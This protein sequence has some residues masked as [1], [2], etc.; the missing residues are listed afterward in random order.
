[1][2]VRTGL[3]FQGNEIKLATAERVGSLPTTNLFA[4]RMV[5]VIT[6]G[7][8]SNPDTGKYYYY[9]G[10]SWIPIEE[11]NIVT[12]IDKTSTNSQIPTAK[13]VQDKIQKEMTDDVDE[14]STVSGK[15]VK[16][17]VDKITDSIIANMSNDVSDGGDVPILQFN[18]ECSIY[19]SLT[20]PNIAPDTQTN[21]ETTGYQDNLP[22]GY[23]L[24]GPAI[25]YRN[26][27]FNR[28]KV[29]VMR[30]G[31]VRI[32]IIRGTGSDCKDRIA[33]G[34]FKKDTR[35]DDYDDYPLSLL[36]DDNATDS[37]CDGQS[38]TMLKKWLVTKFCAYTGVQVFDFPDEIITSPHE[39]I[40]VECRSGT[41]GYMKNNTGAAIE[42]NYGTVPNGTCHTGISMNDSYVTWSDLQSGKYFLSRDMLCDS[43]CFSHGIATTLN[44]S[45]AQGFKTVSWNMVNGTEYVDNN[46]MGAL[47]IGIYRRG[48][49]SD[50]YF[51]PLA[52]EAYRKWDFETN[53]LSTMVCRGYAPGGYEAQQKLAKAK[54]PIYAFEVILAQPGDLSMFLFSSKDPATCKVLKHWTFRLRAIGKQFVHLPEDIVLNE[55]EWIGFGGCTE[56]LTKNPPDADT[57]FETGTTTLKSG[58]FDF[59]IPVYRP[60]A[61]KTFDN[62]NC[63]GDNALTGRHQNEGDYSSAIE[64]FTSGFCYWSGVKYSPTTETE[65]GHLDFTNATFHDTTTYAEYGNTNLCICLHTRSGKISKL[66]DLWCSVTGDSITTYRNVIPHKD[67]FVSK[68]NTIGDYAICYPDAG[69]GLVNSQDN[70][71]W[72]TLIKQT[73]MRFLINEAWSGSKVSGTDSDTAS[74]ACASLIRTSKLHNTIT[75]Y[76]VNTN[77]KLGSPYAY[78]D[79][80]FCMIG[81][82]DIA[83][84]VATGA[85]SNN[86]VTSMDTILGAFETMVYRHKIN[87]PHT[88]RIYFII[89]RGTN[90]YPYQNSNAFSISQFADSAEYI[91]KAFGSYFVPLSYFG[92]L[93]SGYS[94]FSANQCIWIPNGNW[95]RCPGGFEGGIPRD[96]CDHLH[97]APVGNQIIANGLQRFCEN[98]L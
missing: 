59:A 14:I 83:G 19:Y 84:N 75:T 98:I 65:R 95:Y 86:D 60:D 15:G 4:G 73:R 92:S 9:N 70:T 53:P 96:N 30:P 76:A 69:S 36:D 10:E 62:W 21:P 90:S 87:Y 3:D 52:E 64:E 35:Y 18:N 55:G 22:G 67:D 7:E 93:D 29:F 58:Y 85:Y 33:R 78:P 94:G 20:N 97:P 38:H 11:P 24:T 40:F 37:T 68:N 89:P 66:E 13:A 47:N 16:D 8:N 45:P 56:A 12:T 23:V 34:C 2:K 28:I 41:I 61:S 32:G 74:T 1:M 46:Y 54:L 63:F 17:Y 49:T 71:W 80:I 77:N 91:C 81:T 44:G 57:C 79:I 51:S 48:S 43:A 82:N 25:T 42:T 72:G 6:P 31:M 26:K 39:Y 5:V 50:R 88:K 27:V